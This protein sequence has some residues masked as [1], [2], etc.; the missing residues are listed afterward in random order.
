MGENCCMKDYILSCLVVNDGIGSKV[1]R[2]AK[3]NGITGA[4]VLLGK[5]TVKN[6][7]LEFL[8]LN[9]IRKEIVLLI[10]EKNTAYKALEE[11]DSELELHKP[12]HGI[13][14]AFSLS[15]LYGA[16]D[17]NCNVRESRGVVNTMYKAIFAVVDKGRAEAAVD[18]ATTAGSVGATIINARGAGPHETHMLFS[19]AIEPEKEIVMILSEI[20]VVD[21]IVSEIRNELKMDDPGNGLIFV[22]DVDKVYGLYEK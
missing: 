10:G 6:P 2:I 22:L 20:S 13:A 8:A 5:G 21:A 17:C 9:D 15:G 14:F 18:A 7:I 12:N 16:R 19:M 1:T 11:L 4:T 3:Q